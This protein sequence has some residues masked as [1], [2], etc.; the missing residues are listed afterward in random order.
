M[1]RSKLFIGSLI[2]SIV[3]LYLLITQIRGLENN[4]GYAPTQPI[5]FSHKLH[6][7][8]NEISCLYC[9]FGAQYSR[10]AG[11]PPLPVCMN[12]HMNIKK[13]SDAIKD[14]QKILKENKPIEWI[15]VNRLADF[16]YFSHEQHVTVAKLKCQECH[17]AVEKMIALRQE[18]HFTMGFCITCHRE[19]DVEIPGTT[20]MIK[21]AKVGGEDCGK[22]HY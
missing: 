12:C 7:G 13:D 15:K 16:V 21:A 1:L 10:H 11:I 8:D 9:H 4:V 14:I 2:F 5:A 18:N 3:A 20:E 22:C 6:A 17:G 19:K